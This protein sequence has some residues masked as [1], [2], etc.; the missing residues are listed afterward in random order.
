MVEPKFTEKSEAIDFYFLVAKH[1]DRMS[2]M[3]KE[4]FDAGGAANAAKLIGYFTMTK[5][6]ENSITM[7]LPKY[8]WQKKR[9]ILPTI[10]DISWTW[11]NILKNL[12]FFDKISDWF[13]LVHTT[14]YNE[15]VLKIKRPYKPDDVDVKYKD[16]YIA[17]NY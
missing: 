9:E 6:Y 15:G 12:E 17:K 10:P 3:L 8:Y 2:E 16:G 7:F 11:Q 5:H 1:L 14:A 13:Q 4:G